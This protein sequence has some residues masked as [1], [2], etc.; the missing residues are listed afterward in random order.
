VN[1]HPPEWVAGLIGV[2]LGGLLLAGIVRLAL[3]LTFK[4]T[5]PNGVPA[6]N[7]GARTMASL[8]V[9]TTLVVLVCLVMFL[10]P[11]GLGHGVRAL[12]ADVADPAHRIALIAYPVLAIPAYV[13]MCLNVHRA[14]RR[15]RPRI[16]WGTIA[17]VVLGGFAVGLATGSMAYSLVMAWLSL[18]LASAL[19]AIWVKFFGHA[20]RLRRVLEEV[21]RS[22]D[23]SHAIAAVEA[24]IATRGPSCHRIETLGLLHMKAEQWAEALETFRDWESRYGRRAITLNNQAACLRHLGRLDE[25]AALLA[26]AVAEEPQATIFA[27]NYGETLADLGRDDDARA[28]LAVVEKHAPQ[29][30]FLNDAGR[31][32][33]E[34][35]LDR[36]R[37]RIGPIEALGKKA[38]DPLE[39]L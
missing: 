17:A 25:A 5:R 23:P 28:Q 2:L 10:R 34:Q 33:F 29:T 7:P 6:K 32:W 13:A 21:R 31:V 27:L 19:V 14:T 1:R 39:E 3:W 24:E 20:S 15:W 8:Y 11:P 38:A 36:L 18:L 26:E 4:I 37:R 22:G 9:W 16:L 30:R 35:T 12:L